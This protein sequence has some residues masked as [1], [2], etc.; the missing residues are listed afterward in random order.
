MNIYTDRQMAIYQADTSL[1]VDRPV[2]RPTIIKRVK[3]RILNFRGGRQQQKK[4][5]R[6]F[7]DVL[8]AVA[9][10][11][12]GNSR[13]GKDTFPIE[14]ATPHIK[15]AMGFEFNI[16]KIPDNGE[17]ADPILI[18]NYSP[19]WVGVFD[20]LGGSGASKCVI[21]GTEKTEAYFASR[22]ARS[23]VINAIN[24]NLASDIPL[25]GGD[26]AKSINHGLE[27]ELSQVESAPSPLRGSIFKKM[28]TTVALAQIQT[29]NQNMTHNV[30]AY[31]A[32]DSRVYIFTPEQGLIQITGDHLKSSGDAKANLADDSPMSNLASAKEA[33]FIEEKTLSTKSPF[34][35]FAASDGCF[36]YFE[37]TP[38]QFEELLLRSLCTS[39]NMDAWKDALCSELKTISGDDCSMALIAFGWRTFEEMR[40]AFS[41]RYEYIKEI[42]RPI[43]EAREEI[44]KLNRKL[45][46]LNEHKEKLISSTWEA[47]KKNYYCT[48]DVETGRYESRK[49]SEIIS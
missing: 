27:N 11:L 26:I 25:E 7:S 30:S 47:Y 41:P 28:P 33:F 24:S 3:N 14:V 12:G 49:R 15:P 32:G 43:K 38:I 6:K 10:G 19:S 17:D 40:G 46:S 48:D 36:G 1:A 37:D 44:H 2:K 5:R 21:G 34:I 4:R 18:K 35:I 39:R 42:L 22:G 31:W 16:A 13:K 23:A 9:I 45:I 29:D 20:G 8:R